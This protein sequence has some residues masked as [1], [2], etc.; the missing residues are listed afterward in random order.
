DNLIAGVGRSNL[1]SF[2]SYLSEII[3]PFFGFAPTGDLSGKLRINRTGDT[4]TCYYWDSV[5]MSWADILSHTDPV[6]AQDGIFDLRFGLHPDSI[7]GGLP[8]QIAFDNFQ[9]QY[10]Q[11]VPIP[12]TL[13]LLG[14]GLL[15]LGLSE[16]RRKMKQG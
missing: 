8:V 10:D 15:G 1:S 12:P 6:L 9:L 11:L 5:S 16:L 14:S 7:P 13:L 4:I 3:G 2:D